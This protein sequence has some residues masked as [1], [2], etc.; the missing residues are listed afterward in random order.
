MSRSN[1]ICRYLLAVGILIIFAVGVAQAGTERDYAKTGIT[2]TATPF[3]KPYS[4][5]DEN[6]NPSGFFIDY[7]NKW[8]EKTGIPVKFKLVSWSE[9]IDLV[10]KGEA[11]LQAGL[12]F[13]EERAK[14]FDFSTPVFYSKAVMIIG[15]DLS[16][17]LDPKSF[18]WGGVEGTVEKEEALK[19]STRPA[20]A[21]YENSRQLFSALSHGDIQAAVDD[22]S[23]VMLLGSEMQIKK[24]IKICTTVYQKD[25]VAPVL[26]D[27]PLLL[28]LVNEGIGQITEAEKRFLVEKWF[29]GEEAE[30]H[31]WRY[32]APVSVGAVLIALVVALCL[33]LFSRK[34]K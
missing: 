20:I 12:Y 27:R 16:C 28:A 10:A 9:T 13:T 22:W 7:W 25:L 31:W 6:D 19:L 1:A 21:S 11:D 29:I 4:F 15:K 34:G 23:T 17:E 26:Q 32:V 18:T 8:S 33:M 30:S 2:V 24:D 3:W 14:V 5:F